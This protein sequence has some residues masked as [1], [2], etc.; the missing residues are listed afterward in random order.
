MKGRTGFMLKAEEDYVG[1]A[2][3]SRTGSETKAVRWIMVI[4]GCGSWICA[5]VKSGDLDS[6]NDYLDR[7]RSSQGEANASSSCLF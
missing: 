3:S 7:S 5:A 2:L 1:P 6:S 4:A